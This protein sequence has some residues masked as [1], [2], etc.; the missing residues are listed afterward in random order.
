MVHVIEGHPNDL[1]GVWLGARGVAYRIR[2]NGKE[3]VVCCP[4]RCSLCPGEVACASVDRRRGC[5][6]A[7]SCAEVGRCWLRNKPFPVQRSSRSS[8]R[9]GHKRP[10]RHFP[11]LQVSLTV[12]CTTRLCLETGCSYH[13]LEHDAELRHWPPR[14]AKQIDCG[15][16]LPTRSLLTLT[17][18]A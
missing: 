17:Y 4:V 2:V 6:G 5:R 11:P 15:G 8:D 13:L 1:R 12:L 9:N 3:R 16:G 7:L 14:S 10:P 18:Q